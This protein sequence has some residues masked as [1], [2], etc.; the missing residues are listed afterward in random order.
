M[1]E[2]ITIKGFWWLPESDNRTPGIL[3]YKPYEEMVLELFGT[4]AANSK[5]S[6]QDIDFKQYDLIYGVSSD[7]KQISLV[8]SIQ[9]T[10]VLSSN[11][12]FIINKYKSQFLI[13]GRHIQDID[14]KC[15]KKAIVKIPQL[16]LWCSPKNIKYS[17][18]NGQHS[19][20]YDPGNLEI[21]NSTDIDENLTIIIKSG[22]INSLRNAD[23]CMEISLK[24]YTYIEFKCK[25][26]LSLLEIYKYNFIYE[27]FLSLATLSYVQTNNIVLYDC[28]IKCNT[29]PIQYIYVQD[30][31]GNKANSNKG[32]FLFTLEQIKDIYPS[33]LR[34]WY[35]KSEKFSPIRGHLIECIK[36][37][38]TFTEL[39]FLIVMQAVEGFYYRFRKDGENLGDLLSK[40]VD[41]FSDIDVIR[42]SN[43]AVNALKESRHYYSHFMPEGKKKDVLDTTD[44]FLETNK[45]RILLICCTLKFM[46]LS[47]QNI[48][49][50][51]NS[52]DNS[53]IKTNYN[54][55]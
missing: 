24:E 5:Q 2:E 27:Q 36:Y 45:L 7:G 21:I 42:N 6:G 33:L 19:F 4:I 12:P 26:A 53:I 3:A 14:E 46:G 47:N 30:K 34:N 18:D 11:S 50:I 40:L 20:S 17:F 8:K 10:K 9:I 55:E 22:V 1:N 31:E 49:K 37:K 35:A 43:I 39:D 44:L 25:K 51:L 13:I 54:I 48:N 38:T 15:Y 29:T 23:E 16:Y 28:D 41:E 52:S 32:S